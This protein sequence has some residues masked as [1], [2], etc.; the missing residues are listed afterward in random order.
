HAE[1]FYKRLGYETYSDQFLDAGIPHVA[2][3]KEI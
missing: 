2:M 1:Q 3:K